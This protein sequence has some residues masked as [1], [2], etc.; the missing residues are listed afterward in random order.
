VLGTNPNEVVS[1]DADWLGGTGETSQW[2]WRVGIQTTGESRGGGGSIPTP[3]NLESNVQ[4]SYSMK[5]LYLDPAWW[6][7]IKADKDMTG[8]TPAKSDKLT[9][10]GVKCDVSIYKDWR[11][12]KGVTCR[13]GDYVYKSGYPDVRKEKT[14]SDGGATTSMQVEY[15]TPP[16]KV[17]GKFFTPATGTANAYLSPYGTKT[18]PET[19]DPADLWRVTNGPSVANEDYAGQRCKIV[20]Y[21]VTYYVKGATAADSKAFWAGISPQ[22]NPFGSGALAKLVK[23]FS[24]AKARWKALDNK[25]EEIKDTKGKLWAR[26]TRSMESAPGVGGTQWEWSIA[27]SFNNYW[28]W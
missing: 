17:T 23:P 9:I 18:A 8:D 13:V 11:N 16:T 25:V 12:I 1:V 7:M 15:T 24:E 3:E 5:E 2:L 19:G 22:S 4:A 10:D 21:T 26:I 14:P 20:I 27:K 6:G 28:V